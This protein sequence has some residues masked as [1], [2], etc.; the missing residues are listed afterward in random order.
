MWRAHTRSDRV[1][2][3]LDPAAADDAVA[4]VDAPAQRLGSDEVVSSYVAAR[5]GVQLHVR[6]WTS[7]EPRP[8]AAVVFL[9]GIAS[10]GGWFGE[11]AT[12]LMGRGVAGYAPDRRGSGRSGG[13]R[14]HLDHYARAVDDVEQVVRF[15]ATEH[16][17][18]PV[19]LAGSSWAAKLAIVYAAVR[20]ATLAGLMLLG[21]GLLPR[22]TLSPARQVAVGVGHLVTPTARI[23][24]PLT[25]EMYTT[26]PR[27][28]EFI[29][30][31]RLRLLTAT[32][33]FFWETRRLDRRRDRA[34][35]GLRRPLLVQQGDADPMMDVPATR[36]WFAGLRL[37]DKTYH[38]YA[39]ASHT[40][41]F[42]PDRTRYV[43]DIV[44]WLSSRVPPCPP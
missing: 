14:G 30:A 27:Y 32:A 1:S 11:T 8:W 23:A 36:E 43:D 25:P 22:V 16:E 7:A 37:E 24:I 35:A 20:P 29:R 12:D 19:F 3:T 26:T 10:H 17:A 21:P 28:L 13:Q 34:S 2:M 31:D 42:E 41:D 6:R 39:G 40:L 33:Q 15:V 9:H 38:S 18:V 5:D 4:P 44:G